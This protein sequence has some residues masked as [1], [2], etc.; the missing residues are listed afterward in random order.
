MVYPFYYALSLMI[1]SL[2]FLM[3]YPAVYHIDEYTLS[4]ILLFLLSGL[5]SIVGK[6]LCSLS[7]QL[8]E[9]SKLVVFLYLSPLTSMICDIFLFH[10]SI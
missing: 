9:V 7:F 10:I 3:V 5:M 8:E 2:F 6:Q 4:D 1:F